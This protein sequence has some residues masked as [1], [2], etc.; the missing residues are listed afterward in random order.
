MFQGSILVAE[1]PRRFQEDYNDTYAGKKVHS[2]VF[3]DLSVLTTLTFD[4]MHIQHC[5]MLY[6]TSDYIIVFP[7]QLRCV[8][9]NLLVTIP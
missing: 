1:E 7:L 5:T 3:C 9:S 6:Q 2:L 4:T 8:R